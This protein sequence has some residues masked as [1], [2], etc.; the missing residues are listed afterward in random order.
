MDK[1]KSLQEIFGVS[2]NYSE[3]ELRKRF[4]V[5]VKKYH[6]DNKETGNS[7]KFIKVKGIYEELKK[8]LEDEKLY[9]GVFVEIDINN[10]FEVR[11][12]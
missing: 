9:S 12:F 3:E 11:V 8:R 5:L 4:R 6:T 10:I 1:K 7:R 2:E